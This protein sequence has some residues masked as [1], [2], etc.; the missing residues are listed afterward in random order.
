MK[1]DT[2]NNTLAPEIYAELNL[3][4]FVA[5]DLETTGL[6]YTDS[7]II[8]F[9]AVRFR[10]G[11][12]AEILESLI[13][14]AGNIPEFITKLTGIAN[15]DVQ[16]A[17]A[18]SEKLTEIREFVGSAPL[19]AHNV[20]FDLPF[21]E[22][23][24][25]KIHGNLSGWNARSRE[26]HYFPNPKYD[27]VTLA[28][29]YL[30]HLPSFSMAALARFFQLPDKASHR[31]L[32]DARSCGLLFR[33]LLHISLKTPFTDLQ[34]IL[35]ILQPTDDPIF[36][37]FETLVRFQH[38]G[39]YSVPEGIDRRQF[40]MKAYQYNILGDRAAPIPR[41]L[42]DEI[43][44]M[45]DE[46]DWQH[47][48]WDQMHEWV[49]KITRERPHLTALDEDDIAAF[50]E[51][52]G[53]LAQQFGVFEERPQQVAMARA[54]AR[55][56]N[57]KSFLAVE[58][59]TGTGKSLAYLVPA[60]QW[61]LKNDLIDGRVVI[62]TNTKNL[63]EQLF[64]KDL[65]VLSSIMPEKFKAVLLKGRNNYLCLDKWQTVMRDVD[66]RLGE[67]DRLDFLPL[68]FWAKE[69][70]TGDIAE[71]NA[72][73]RERNGNL[74]G[75]FIAESQ[76]CPG[77]KCK[78]YSQCHLMKAR[79]N[80]RDAHL[81]LVNH[82][83]LF[84]DL[85]NE[86]A[87]IGE[88][89]N[90]ILDEAHNLEK[91]ATEYLGM[92]MTPWDFREVTS[93]LYAIEKH[94]NGVLAQL[95]RNIAK[96][97]LSTSELD[98]LE[99]S[100]Q[101]LIESTQDVWE[102]AQQFF[103]TATAEL[104][105]SQPKGQQNNYASRYR[106]KS[107]RNPF[108]ALQTHYEALVRRMVRLTARLNNTIEGF[109][110]FQQDSFPEQDQILR[111][112]KAQAMKT[113]MLM[114]TLEHLLA[115]SDDSSVYWYE[116]PRRE[117]SFDVRMYMAP[118]NIGEILHEK[119]YKQLQTAVFTSATLAVNREFSYF[120]QRSGIMHLDSERIETLRLDSPFDYG[121]QVFLGIPAYF[122]P[123]VGRDNIDHANEATRQLVRRLAKELPRG[124][125]GLFT[126]YSALNEVYEGVS[127]DLQMVRIPLLAQGKDGGRHVI[128]NRF[129]DEAPAFLFGTDSF[130]EGVDVPG[131][132]L[133]LLLITKLPFDVP[134]D[135][136]FQAKKEMIEKR[137]GNA[138]YELSVPE[139]VIRFR[140]GFG[141]L[142]RSR[143]DFGAVLVLDTRVIKKSYGQVFLRSLPARSVTL[144]DE[145]ELMA[146]LKQ[147][148]R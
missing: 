28:R 38:G 120:L 124:T 25:R 70:E 105:A 98:A 71:N 100:V 130:W 35:R 139:A 86:N 147:W 41:L 138:F 17:P 81:V 111:D 44:S 19:I 72:F 7:E 83:L 42:L 91:V 144:A 21:L 140:Q 69:T 26:Y 82:S 126:S 123:P 24:A 116:M 101:Q 145:D 61:A 14:P 37:F 143:R 1:A 125:L 118:L 2:D 132:A 74:W 129:K 47:L 109:S 15:A 84:S 87:V 96:G 5:L 115:A 103:R 78:L 76:Y 18:F 13:K 146:R 49:K 73:R 4:E 133:E 77:R 56:F 53:Q 110:D 117:D 122:P 52:G 33:E 57:Q 36:H 51:K 10:D 90:L 64:F 113:E 8:E 3:S 85:A 54:I 65:P 127:S 119:L 16:D 107:D 88:Y 62:S 97:N 134:T 9:A 102:E 11:K 137:G 67:K 29:L 45:L 128:L 92:A 39:R 63:Q 93:R 40:Y 12:P 32:P 95:K 43:K 79:E 75:K 46:D 34:E 148:F 121:E 131:E 99:R 30:P 48:D 22:Y 23:H 104:R 6:R 94:E 141:R 142:I 31:A 114:G 89:A 68:Y 108:A 136:I 112:L 66:S 59:G 50:F 55:A 58:A 60:I 20:N 27:T 80:A 135:P 106:Y